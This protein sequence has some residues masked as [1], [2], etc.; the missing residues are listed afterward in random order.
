M[1]RATLS[2]HINIATP[3][4]RRKSWLVAGGILTV[5]T[6]LVSSYT[7]WTWLNRLSADEEIQ[8]RT[9]RQAVSRIELELGDARLRVTA[10]QDGEVTI[11]RQLRSVT[12]DSMPMIEESWSGDTLRITS[13]C[14]ERSIARY[15]SLGYDLRAPKGVILVAHTTKGSIDVVGMAG[16]QRLTESNGSLTVTNAT[17]PLTMRT[18]SGSI[19][20]NGLASTNVDIE[21]TS[22]DTDLDFADPPRLVAVKT[23]TG[24]V[25]LRVPSGD[26]YQVSIDTSTG[27]SN[28]S[29]RV[30]STAERVLSVHTTSGNVDVGYT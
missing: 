5:I 7:L 10:G 6:V 11:N 17:G 21:S 19:R 27:H 23:T 16:E 9:Y 22:G 2:L 18:S 13:H 20:G 28:R 14:P 1:S 24:D 30:E 26:A 3:P 29:L 15:C 25:A 4:H 8:H 12:P